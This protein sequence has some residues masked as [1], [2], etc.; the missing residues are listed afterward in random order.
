MKYTSTEIC[1]L[2]NV[3]KKTLRHYD[4]IGLLSPSL[5]NDNG[6]WYYDDQALETIQLIKNL[7][8]IGYS[9]KEIKGYL[10]N[11]F[12]GLR[13]SIPD[14]LRFI[15]EQII[16]LELAK[17][18]L[19]KLEIKKELDPYEAVNESMD[20]EHI[21]WYEKNLQPDQYNLVKDLME[22]PN[23]MVI[24][25]K[26]VDYLYKLK[27]YIQERNLED[28]NKTLDQIRALFLNPNFEKNTVDKLIESFL[29][30]NLEGPL[31]RRILTVSEVVYLLQRL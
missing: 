15:D 22:D 6:Y 7:Q 11:D 23:S 30:S 25:E 26:L 19:R 17:R 29:K 9:L 31:S 13:I 5:I 2:A 28:I 3:T 10:L 18:L 12:Q 16:Q 20:E 1:T 8:V 21:E 27:P 14:K 24:H 4:K